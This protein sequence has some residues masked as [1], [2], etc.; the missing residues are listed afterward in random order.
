MNRWVSWPYEGHGDVDKFDY[1][2]HH[3]ANYQVNDRCHVQR[4]Q[5]I[6]KQ[7]DALEEWDISSKELPIDGD[8][9]TAYPHYAE[10]NLE[11]QGLVIRIRSN[12]QHTISK[13]H[14]VR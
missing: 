4:E 3:A 1:D 10:Y 13:V 9:S 2:M 7:T 6:S 14:L 11:Q 8:H 5:A 12:A